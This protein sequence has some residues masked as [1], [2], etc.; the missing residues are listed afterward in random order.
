[1]HLKECSRHIQFLPT[2]EDAVCMSLPRSLIQNKLKSQNINSK[3]M[4]MTRFVDRYNRLNQRVFD[5]FG[6]IC[7]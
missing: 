3:E 4:W 2:G 6:Y 1:M 7:I 5:V